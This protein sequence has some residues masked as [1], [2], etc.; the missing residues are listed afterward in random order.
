MSSD[1]SPRFV[2]MESS[3]PSQQDAREGRPAPVTE[4]QERICVNCGQRYRPGE[5]ICGNCGVLFTNATTHTNKLD[6]PD[7]THPERSKRIG[8]AITTHFRPLNLEI[9]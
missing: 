5:L 4:K 8:K 6:S 7:V 1:S 2:H 3:E 9:A